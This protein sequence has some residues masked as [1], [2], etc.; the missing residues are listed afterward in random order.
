MSVGP[1]CACCA[2]RA[3]RFCRETAVHP[4]NTRSE[5]LD[6]NRTAKARPTSA[7]SCSAHAVACK[8]GRTKNLGREPVARLQIDGAALPNTSAQAVAA[9]SADCAGVRSQ[10]SDRYVPGKTCRTGNVND[11]AGCRAAAFAVAACCGGLHHHRACINLGSARL[12]GRRAT[13]RRASSTAA[14]PDAATG[15][16][17]T[18]S[19]VRLHAD[20]AELR[21]PV[22]KQERLSGSALRPGNVAPADRVSARA[23]ASAGLAVSE[24]ARAANAA[25]PKCRHGQSADGQRPIAGCS[26]DCVQAPGSAPASAPG[27]PADARLASAPRSALSVG[28]S[29]Y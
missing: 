21:D 7:G 6:Q 17:I 20:C 13:D 15:T 2:A 19:G 4:Q 29:R 23:A 9:I 25:C 22:G 14:S 11:P 5:R 28:A 18:A 1:G 26:G 10:R 3:V 12:K 27:R 24:S 16:A 8:T